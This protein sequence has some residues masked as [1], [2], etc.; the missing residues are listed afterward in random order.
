MD[1]RLHKRLNDHLALE[2]GAAHKYLAMALW[3]EGHDLA[4]FGVWLRKQS[5]EEYGHALRIVNHL[6]ER[7]LL[8]QLPAIEQPRSTFASARAVV[9]AVLESERNV[10]RAIESLYEL[11]EKTNDRPAMFMLQWFVTEQVEEE[12]LVRGIL[13]RLK[14]AGAEGVGLLLVDQEVGGTTASE[15]AEAS[16]GD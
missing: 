4:G 6:V 7:D 8:V 14:L 10:T 1:K 5:T 12:K 16:A 15:N 2:F 9:E 3:C 11:A 13:G